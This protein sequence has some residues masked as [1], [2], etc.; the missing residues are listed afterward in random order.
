[1]GPTATGKTDLAL[2]LVEKYPQLEIISVDSAMVYRG[3][4]IGTAKPSQALL[5]RIPHRL[6][7]IRDP[8]DAY[9]AAD[10]CHDAQSA[11]QEI[12]ARGGTPLLVGGTMLYFRAL[13]KGLSELPLADPVTRDYFTERAKVEG[14]EAL[15]T[16][17][18]EVDPVAAEK[19]H[20]NDPQRIQR[21]LEVYTLTGQPI[22]ELQKNPSI[23]D[24]TNTEFINIVLMPEPREFLHQKIALRVDQML[25]QGLIEEVRK[26]YTR[27]DLNLN[28]PAVRAVGYQQV[29]RYIEGEYNEHI[30]REKIIIATRQLAKRQITWLRTWP[31]ANYFAV[32]QK[33]LIRQI[34]LFLVESVSLQ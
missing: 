5:D 23:T 6:I 20:P 9:S 13:Q 31:N 10:F 22:S 27:K 32:P 15:H 4:D 25:E 28:M 19:I 1:M 2:E 7:N 21:A 33:N 26:L 29:W 34:Q 14:W 16:Y 11:I 18:K 17:L 30:L 12:T 8:S 3:M 24:N